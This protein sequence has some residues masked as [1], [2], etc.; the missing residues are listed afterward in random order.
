[1]SCE[2]DPVAPERLEDLPE[3][4]RIAWLW[5]HVLELDYDGVEQ[6][7]RDRARTPCAWDANRGSLDLTGLVA[8]LGTDG[9]FHLRSRDGRAVCERTRRERLRAPNPDPIIDHE[10]Y[11]IWSTDGTNYR[12]HP[13]NGAWDGVTHTVTFRW[14]VHLTDS[15]AD[16]SAVPKSDRCPAQQSLIW[17]PAHHNPKTRDGRMRALLAGTF[18]PECHA[19]GYAPGTGIDHDHFTGAV[20]GLLCRW[21]NN[22]VDGCPHLRGCPWADY[23]NDPPAARLE[24]T[25]PRRGKPWRTPIHADR[26][27]ALGFDP[28]E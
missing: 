17:W 24:L 1:M 25:Y 28:F 13:P 27:Q 5:K 26:V 23:L 3:P 22:R 2:Y 4:R 21:C 6:L 18:G 15:E 7:V 19:C 20:R 9:R 11:L 16:P 10:S 12:I 8:V 14:S